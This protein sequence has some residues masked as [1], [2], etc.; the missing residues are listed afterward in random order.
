LHEQFNKGNVDMTDIKV[1][2]VVEI[3]PGGILTSDGTLHKLDVIAL[4]TGF[5]S[6]TGGMKNT[7]LRSIYGEVLSDV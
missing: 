1:N 7:D 2:P 3:K 4:A 6:I 5:E